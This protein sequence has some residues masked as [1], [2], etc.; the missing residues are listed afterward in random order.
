MSLQKLGTYK[1]C[2]KRRIGEITNRIGV[3]NGKDA[4]V[5]ELVAQRQ[6]LLQ[7]ALWDLHFLLD[8]MEKDMRTQFILMQ[9]FLQG[10]RLI[11]WEKY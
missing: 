1:D 10:R 3:V 9:T 4:G 5:G 6:V 7:T 2:I 8:L 11:Y